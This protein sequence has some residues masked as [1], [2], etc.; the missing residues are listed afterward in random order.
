MFT[1]FVLVTAVAALLASANV[2]Q[3]AAQKELDKLQGVWAIVSEET[4]GVKLSDDKLQSHKV[5]IKGNQWIQGNDKGSQV[6]TFK[7]DPAK[8]P[9]SIDFSYIGPKGKDNKWVGI[10]KIEDDTLT[11]CRAKGNLDRPKEF[12][13]TADGGILTVWKKAKN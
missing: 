6:V 10:Y 11:V 1:R 4:N 3:D 5:T 12:K 2:Q 8:N 13:T 9:K 7:L